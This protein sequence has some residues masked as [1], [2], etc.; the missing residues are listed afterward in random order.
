MRLKKVIAA[1]LA[2]VMLTFPISAAEASD[3]TV[4][5]V[6][7]AV[8]EERDGEKM[9]DGKKLGG[10]LMVGAIVSASWISMLIFKGRDKTKYL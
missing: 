7:E 10:I 3:E 6:T 9:S 1:T 8:T 4:S 5:E 2:A